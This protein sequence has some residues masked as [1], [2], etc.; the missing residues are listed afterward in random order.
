MTDIAS[1]SSSPSE[2]RVH[3]EDF[4]KGALIG[5]G[6]ATV[7]LVVGAIYTAVTKELFR[8][9]FA[10]FEGKDRDA[11]LNLLDGV[12]PWRVAAMLVVAVVCRT[13]L[14]RH[15]RSDFAAWISASALLSI[16]LAHWI[17]YP[18]IATCGTLLL[19]ARG[20]VSLALWPL[21]TLGV[22]GFITRGFS[23]VPFDGPAVTH[24]GLHM[25]AISQI[26]YFMGAFA[27]VGVLVRGL[28]SE[29]S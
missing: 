14:A 7:T 25:I 10:S 2:P 6:C 1:S 26:A 16:T 20:R 21:A 15:E 12:V 17:E 18:I 19:C 4:S 24:A 28:T 13:A 11:Y 23:A 9:V 8:G 5:L 3:P 29:P 22:S 27:L